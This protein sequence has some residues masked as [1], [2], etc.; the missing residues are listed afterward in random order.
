MGETAESVDIAAIVERLRLG[1]CVLCAGSRL[2]SDGDYR[3]LVERLC[4][5]LPDVDQADVD[6]VLAKRPLA[7]AGYVRRRLGDKFTDELRKLTAQGGEVSEAVKI[8]ASLPFRAVVTTTYD[9]TFERVLGAAGQAPVVYTPADHAELRKDGRAKFVFKALGDPARAETVVWSAEDLQSALA[10]GGYRTLAH[11]LYRS[12][13]FLFV[14]FDGQDPDL[15]I[16]LERVLS[17]AR[18]SDVEHWAV[19]PG[20]TPIEKEELYAAY[21]IRVLDIEDAG[22]L[23]RALKDTIGDQLG[24]ILPDDDDLEGW[25]GL[26]TEEPGRADALDRLDKLEKKLRDLGEHDRLVEYFLGRVGV[27]QDAARR[28]AMLGEVARIFE[29]EV[30]DL[31]KA[32]TAYLAAYKEAPAQGTWD[33]LERLASATGMWTE[34]LA[35]L[36]EIVPSLPEEARAAAWVRIARLYGDKLG[37]VE[38][39]LTSIAEAVK[40]APDNAEAQAMRV[41]LLRR[42]ERWKDL[43]D[44]LQLSAEHEASPGERS[45][46]Y[47]EL[48]DL[49]ETRLGDGGQAIHCY[50]KAIE[51][52]P[53][54]EEARGALEALLRRRGDWKELVQLLDV[55]ATSLSGEEATALKRE[56]AEILAERLGDKRGAIDR[57]EALRTET[58][59]DLTVLRAL[60]RLYQ[61][62][63]RHED[64]LTVLGYQAEAVESD[65][66]RAALYRRLA[67]EWEE[68]PGGAARAEEYLEKLLGVDARSEDAFRSLERLYRGD[69]KW[70]ELIDVLKRH[71]GIVPAPIRAEL[72]AQVGA[73]YENEQKDPTQAIEAYLEV[74]AALPTHG[75]AL[76]ALS[77]LYERTEAWAKAVDVLDKRAQLAEVKSQKVELFHRAGELTAERLGDAK[78][79]EQR[80]MRALELDHVFVPAMT[81]L[82][83][84][85]RKN[86]EFLRAAKLLIEAVPHTHNRLEKTRL[87]VEAGELYDGLEDKRKATELYLEALAVDPEHVEAGERVADLLYR[88][89]RWAELAPVLEM[90]TRKE[91]DHGVTLERLLRLAHAAKVLGD[92]DKAKKAYGRAA[93]LD[94]TH[95][96]AQQGRAEL[97]WEEQSY[98]EARAALEKVFEHHVEDLPPSERVELFY[99]LGTC[100]RRLERKELARDWFQRALDI[101][102]THRPSILAMVEFGEAKPEGLIDAKKALIATASPDEKVKLLTEI[103]DLYLEKLE[104]PPQGL[105]AYR[106]ALEIRPDDHKLLHKCLDVYVEQKAWAQGLEM[107]ERLIAIEKSVQVRAK[108]RHAAGLICRDELGRPDEAAK[109]LYE[110]LD[111]DPSLD[112]SAQALEELFTERQDW[113]ELARFYRRALKRIGPETGDGRNGERLRLWSA[114]GDVCLERLGERESAIAAFEVALTLAPNDTERRKRIADLYVQAG[115]ERFDKAVLEHQAILRGEKNRIISYRALKHLYIQTNQREKS[116]A[117]SYAL[118]FLKKGEPDDVK[119][120]TELKQRPLPQ[121]RRP[122]NDEGWARVQHPDEDRYL[123]ALF[124]AVSGILTLGQAQPHKQLGLNP[125]QAI[126]ATDPRPFNRA[127]RY[128]ASALGL[129]PPELYARPEIP[130]PV[131]FVNCAEKNALQPVFILGQPLLNDKRHERELVFELARRLAYLRP[132]RLLRLVLPTPVQIAHIIDAAVALAAEADQEKGASPTGELAKTAMGL[133]RALPPVGLEQVVAVGRRLARAGLRADQAALGWLQAADLTA[134]RI[135]L[136]LAGDLETSARILAAEPQSAMTLP[137]TQRLLDLVWSSVTEET[138]VVR[139]HLGTL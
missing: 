73:I 111:D 95:L 62:E 14:G 25:L 45:T 83:E 49:Y 12:R 60:E 92:K 117:C 100:E 29:N 79:A 22:A 24:P 41:G 23:A 68:H 28:A 139:K 84:I 65:K 121:V 124:A 66:E 93:E 59:R 132:E 1:R 31:A 86:G 88:G 123:S 94:P 18:S 61:Q 119:V 115:P 34:L 43:A 5:A 81:A 30:G 120:A 110:A 89:E 96:E 11:D 39:A 17:G 4:K 136:L 105:G 57:Y 113:K 67:T 36:T 52:D 47:L 134:S 109:H 102:A 26:L 103:G 90:L 19:L 27:E 131:T 101:D 127:L 77:R 13:S 137:T 64:Y 33:E 106:E 42:A 6:R 104:D 129:P 138:F 56:V 87:L 98:P 63:G 20:L 2:G 48:A 114:L 75:E 21:R 128:C 72:Y 116:R 82:V 74:E 53:L 38:Y 122:L 71:A 37:H 8:F 76:A 70:T 133:K 108:Y 69:H 7:A 118:T 46:L 44:A 10:D 91:A 55:K 85:Y 58:P 51:A 50:R 125:K 35:E 107:L 97:A 80:F 126:E 9:D 99:R 112:R 32:F 3:S 15:G 54:A 135:G 130:E 78:G 16:L 40:L